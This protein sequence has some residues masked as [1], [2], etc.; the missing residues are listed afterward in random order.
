MYHVQLLQGVLILHIKFP[1]GCITFYATHCNARSIQRIQT[2][3]L[4]LN[5][6]ERVFSLSDI[7]LVASRMMSN[8]IRRS[9]IRMYFIVSDIM[10]N[11]IRYYRE[12]INIFIISSTRTQISFQF[13]ELVNIITKDIYSLDKV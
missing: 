5:L 2:V 8:K 4:S 1:T 12:N 3:V 7:C 13:T 10:Q 6:L 9:E 11:Q